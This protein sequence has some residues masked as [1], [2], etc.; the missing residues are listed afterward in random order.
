M[1]F[2]E[3]KEALHGLS[4]AQWTELRET[5]DALEEGVSVEEWRAMKAAVDEE[6]NDP[7]EEL[8]LEEVREAINSLKPEDAPES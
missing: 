8:S 2:A 5:L 7:S 3:I 4:P 6:L 1:S